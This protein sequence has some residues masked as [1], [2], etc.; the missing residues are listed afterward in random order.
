[1]FLLTEILKNSNTSTY[2]IKH[3]LNSELNEP[4]M[5][6]FIPLFG[7]WGACNYYVIFSIFKSY[8]FFHRLINL[9][10]SFCRVVALP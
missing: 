1:M 3:R 8:L 4:R 9:V 5:N 7:R 2:L 6:V 10:G